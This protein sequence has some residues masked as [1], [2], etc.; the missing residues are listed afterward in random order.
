MPRLRKRQFIAL[1]EPRG[2][3][4][5]IASESITIGSRL[6]LWHLH[7]C[8]LGN[9]SRVFRDRELRTEAARFGNQCLLPPLLD[10]AKEPW[11]VADRQ[12]YSQSL[13]GH[14][15]QRVLTAIWSPCLV[16]ITGGCHEKVSNGL[17]S[18]GE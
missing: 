7:Q 11:C 12:R 9:K 4:K 5:L 3:S 15:N 17:S 2:A 8:G 1:Q 10:H 18:T 14:D 6:L 16:T 13:A